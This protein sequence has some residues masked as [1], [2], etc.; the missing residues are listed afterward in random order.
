MGAAETPV[1]WGGG[2]IGSGKRRDEQ[3]VLETD[4]ADHWMMWRSTAADDDVRTGQMVMMMGPC[5]A[6][7][8]RSKAETD[9]AEDDDARQE[10]AVVSAGGKGCCAS[11][12]C[13]IG[14][15]T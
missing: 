7:E 15:Y 13:H 5:S 4:E 3:G 10:E 8:G 6:D 14:E 11:L 2:R 9:D 12:T 1:L